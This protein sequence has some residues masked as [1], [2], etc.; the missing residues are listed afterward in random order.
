MD[1]QLV[2]HLSCS[3]ANQTHFAQT[4]SYIFQVVVIIILL[5]IRRHIK[6]VSQNYVNMITICDKAIKHPIASIRDLSNK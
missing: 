5:V 6:L 3:R 1:L 4:Y 2:I